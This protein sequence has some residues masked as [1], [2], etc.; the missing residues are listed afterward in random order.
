M[1]VP[2]GLLMMKRTHEAWSLVF[3][4]GTTLTLEAVYRRAGVPEA[5]APAIAVL[6][7][8]LAVPMSA[9]RQSPDV[10]HLFWPGPP[11]CDPGTNRRYTLWGHRGITHRYWFAALVSVPAGLLP[12]L[13][14]ARLGVPWYW[15]PLALA[16]VSGWWSHLAG[17]Q[18]YGRLRVMGRA[19]GL[20]WTTDGPAETGRRKNGKPRWII[21]PAAKV[22]SVLSAALVLAHLVLAA[23]VLPSVVR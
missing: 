15:L 13:V 20:G 14:L 5:V 1:V 16:P 19:R 3:W 23:G 6:G 21:D 4:L 17:D 9:G 8:P 18:I 7:A 11:R 12:V 10:D 22:C 2:G